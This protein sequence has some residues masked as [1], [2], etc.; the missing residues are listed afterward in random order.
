MIE[1]VLY[2]K[3]IIKIKLIYSFVNRPRER[4]S[5]ISANNI[6]CR[7]LVRLQ[8]TAFQDGSYCTVTGWGMTDGNDWNDVE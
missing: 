4:N 1:T 8:S 7:L 6:V 2:V 5:L 3:K